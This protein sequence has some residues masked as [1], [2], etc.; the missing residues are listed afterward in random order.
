MTKMKT[1]TSCPICEN[2][3]FNKFLDVKDHFLTKE[4]FTIVECKE[5]GFHFTNPIPTEDKIGEY[6]KSEKYVSHNSNKGGIINFIYNIVRKR[7]L[8]EKARIV[9]HETEGDSLLDFGSGSGHF[10]KAVNEFGF[11]GV[12]IEP[13]QEARDYAHKSKG[14]KSSDVEVFHKYEKNRFD[15]VTMWHVLEH[16]PNLEQDLKQLHHILKY[17]GKLIIAVPNMNSYDAKHYKRFWAAYD[18]PRHLYHFRQT[19]VA[20][21][22]LKHDFQLRKVIPMKY[23]AYYISMLSE[24]YRSRIMPFGIIIG[25]ISNLKAKTFGYSSQIYVFE[26]I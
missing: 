8:D 25:F 10:L 16:I 2:T 3:S 20:R 23:D 15:I 26:K 21:L 22:L 18:V 5:C 6:Y 14:V 9:R 19:D 13:S 1:I 4:K 12:G 7:T 24:K 11:N 17:N